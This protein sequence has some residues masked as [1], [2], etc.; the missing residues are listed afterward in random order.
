[1]ELGKI[2]QH[3]GGYHTPAAFIVGI[4]SLRQIYHASQGFLSEVAIF[5]KI[6][7]SFILFQNNHPEKV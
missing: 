5:P 1:M 3:S 6:S 7:Y 4:G 2:H